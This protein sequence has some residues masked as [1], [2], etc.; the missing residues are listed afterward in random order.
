MGGQGFISV[1]ITD[2]ASGAASQKGDA[3]TFAEH[4]G[5]GPAHRPIPLP[6]PIKI[7]DASHRAGPRAGAGSASPVARRGG[8]GSQA[9]AGPRA[10][11][12]AA[13]Y[14]ASMGRQ[15][16]SRPGSIAHVGGGPR[17]LLPSR[18]GEF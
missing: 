13:G 10:A 2:A 4:G 18:R 15:N 1:E 8:G 5:V 11:S 7:G 9:S 3:A 12:L 14:P 16:R 17:R 6:R